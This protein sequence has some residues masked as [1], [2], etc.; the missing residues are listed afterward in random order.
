MRITLLL[1]LA[2]LFLAPR[3]APCPSTLA[4]RFPGTTWMRYANPREAGFSVPRLSEAQDYWRSL[5]SAALLVVV[6]GAVLVAWGDVERR[7]MVHS[8]R[9][10]V[11]S[12]V[13]GRMVD[14]G[15]IDLDETLRKLGIDDRN[16]ELSDQE[17]GATIRDLLCAR[18]G[19]Y[20]AAAAEPP[21]NTKPPR[22]SHAP[23]TH[24]CY[25]NWDFNALCTILEEQTGVRFFEEVEHSLAAPLGMQDYRVRDGV[26]AY[27]EQKSIH[28]AYPLRM[29]ARDMA[30]L[31]H[32]YLR[33]GEWA[34]ERLLSEEW[35]CE[36]TYPHS[37]GIGGGRGY[38]YMWWVS[39]A[40][41]FVAQGMVSALGVGVQSIDVLPE[42]DMVVVHR[43]DTFAGM[44]VSGMQRLHL[45]RML[46]DAQVGE[47]T[48]DPELLPLEAV[49]RGWKRV[50]LSEALL[51]ATCGTHDFPGWGG[52]RVLRDSDELLFENRMGT[53][54][55]IP[56]SENRFQLEDVEDR[57]YL[58]RAG[59]GSVR[60]VLTENLLIA[61]GYEQ[62]HQGRA[63]EAIAAFERAVLCFPD[64]ANAYDSLGEAYHAAGRWEESLKGYRRSLELDPGNEGARDRIEEL[65]EILGE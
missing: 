37:T 28:P 65:E 39:Q 31:G 21:Q 26:Y 18:S 25:N 42:A 3:T 63:E 23:G 57:F 20:H 11:M 22:G 29:S 54:A 30:R 52:A 47:P 19:V 17:R 59:D 7:F 58:E 51:D 4:E 34:G 35:I 55:L 2:F 10:S 49:R 50:H 43:T 46:L 9:K 48:A 8:V 6:D 53:F 64:A 14:A 24:W 27:E 15:R 44:Q 40:E 45:I 36:S 33:G 5:D 61:A 38:G 13:Y 60:Q 1:P 32:L 41:P 16:P 62:L 12:A 56:L